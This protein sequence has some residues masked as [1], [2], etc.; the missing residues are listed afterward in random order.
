MVV[1]NKV[2]DESED[3]VDLRNLERPVGFLAALSVEVEVCLA[4]ILYA[5]RRG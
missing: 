5:A 1:A 4:L 3:F 2:R